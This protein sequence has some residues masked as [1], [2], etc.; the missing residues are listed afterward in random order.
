MATH[1]TDKWPPLDARK[2]ATLTGD[3]Q[4]N[5]SNAETVVFA[6]PFHSKGALQ[7]NVFPTGSYRLEKKAIRSIAKILIGFWDLPRV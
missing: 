7:K 5:I 1:S 3:D 2:V 4:C 6:A